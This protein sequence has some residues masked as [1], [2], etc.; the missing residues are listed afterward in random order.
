MVDGRTEDSNLGVCGKFLR[1]LPVARAVLK[2][3]VLIHGHQMTAAFSQG[4]LHGLVVDVCQ[5]AVLPFLH[6]NGLGE[7]VAQ[8]CQVGR[9]LAVVPHQ[10]PIGHIGIGGDVGGKLVSVGVIAN[11][12]HGQFELV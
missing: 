2:Q 1:P 7:K 3:R 9:L 12:H 10:E 6:Y 5:P 8:L 4:Q 11:Y